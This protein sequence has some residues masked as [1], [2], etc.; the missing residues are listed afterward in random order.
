MI[1]FHYHPVKN[2]FQFPLWFFPL[3]YRLFRAMWLNVQTLGTFLVIFLLLISSLIPL[4][5]YSVWFQSF[6][7]YW[8]LLSSL[9]YGLLW[10][11]FQKQL[12]FNLAS[13]SEGWLGLGWDMWGSAG[14]PGF[15]HELL[16]RLHPGPLLLCMCLFWGLSQRSSC[17]PGEALCLVMT[18]TRGQVETHEVFWGLGL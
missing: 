15:M 17:S 10:W 12:S 6:K 4:W 5:S 2:I 13:T 18:E 16:C 11:M 3:I 9:A 7:M 14:P 1:H 8:D